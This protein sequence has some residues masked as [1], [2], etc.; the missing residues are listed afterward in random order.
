VAKLP[1]LP[2]NVTLFQS[3]TDFPADV[4]PRHPARVV[5]VVENNVHHCDDG[6]SP[7]HLRG[8]GC[9]F[10]FNRSPNPAYVDIPARFPISVIAA[11]QPFGISVNV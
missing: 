2:N 11:D 6:H 5:S 4:T 1:S 10:A 9:G 3:L 8:S 7:S